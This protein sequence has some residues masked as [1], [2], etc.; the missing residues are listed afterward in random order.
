MIERDENQIEIARSTLGIYRDIHHHTWEI[1]QHRGVCNGYISQK[2][3]KIGKKF[4]Q[5]LNLLS[6]SNH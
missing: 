6:I 1:E 3:M 4:C 2:L 5:Q